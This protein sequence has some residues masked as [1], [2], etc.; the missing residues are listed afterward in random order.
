MRGARTAPYKSSRSRLAILGLWPPSG[1]GKLYSLQGHFRSAP[2]RPLQTC[3]E[4]RCF[5][6]VTP[7]GIRCHSPCPPTSFTDLGPSQTGP[8]PPRAVVPP[9][10]TRVASMRKPVLYGSCSQFAVKWICI[11]NVLILLCPH[12]TI[13]PWSSFWLI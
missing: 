8:R 10:K 1:S 7:W 2:K 3:D 5:T 12:S 6:G 4:I 11:C 9:W 13:L